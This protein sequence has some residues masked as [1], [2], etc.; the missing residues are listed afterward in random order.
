MWAGAFSYS[1]PT[2]T[3]AWFFIF[4]SL[5]LPL[6]FPDSSSFEDQ[7]KH[8]W[9]FTSQYTP[10]GRI[11]KLFSWMESANNQLSANK[12]SSSGVHCH[13]IIHPYYVPGRHNCW[14]LGN[15]VGWILA[16][17]T[18]TRK[19]IL[20][21]LRGPNVIAWAV[22]N[23]HKCGASL[24]AQQLSSHIPLHRPRVHQF[25]SQVRTYTPLVKP[26]HGSHTHIK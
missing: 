18:F 2:L 5:L 17:M 25:G 6:S 14:C 13:V 16:P 3:P 15:V 24:V 9:L 7:N 23:R 10:I 12:T 22:K 26:C 19:M 4:L 1:G 20:D 21:S 8:K 11:Q